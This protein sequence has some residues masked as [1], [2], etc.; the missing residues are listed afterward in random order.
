MIFFFT[1]TG[2]SGIVAR[3]LA[4]ALC[5]PDPVR[6]T[7]AVPLRFALRPGERVVWVFP[8]YSWGVPPVVRRFMRAV[9]LD[10]GDAAVHSMVCTCGDDC[11]LTSA[12]WRRELR[13]R[14]WHAGC[15]YSVEMPNT[16]VSLPGFDVDA[17]ATVRRKLDAMPARVAEAARAISVGARVDDTV[18][19]SFAWLKTHVI[20]PFF[21]RFLM[22]P[23]PFRATDG[24]IG[25]S[26]C[27][28]A[29]PM[30]NVSLDPATDRP[31]WGSDCAGCLA[32]YHACPRHAVA[33]G[34]RTA[35]K[36]QYRAQRGE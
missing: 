35:R 6:I 22:S 33:Y 36:G 29:C 19:G 25:C 9:R 26:I 3:R 24:C 16:Y 32:C 28:R 13:R 7:D 18:R 30:H 12:Q 5:E 4:D 8:V 27:V 34:S 10:G 11:G 1:G 17:P 2:N 21:V 23:R 20:Y 31:R 15:A 14:G